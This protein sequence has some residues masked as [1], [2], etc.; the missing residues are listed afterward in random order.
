MDQ[1]EILKQL[2]Y[3]WQDSANEFLLTEANFLVLGGYPRGVEGRNSYISAR[4]VYQAFK[5]YAALPLNEQ[6]VYL[7]DGP[8]FDPDYQRKEQKTHFTLCVQGN[9]EEYS[10]A[11]ERIRELCSSSLIFKEGKQIKRQEMII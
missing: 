6:N 1:S 2:G 9:P 8:I 5:T 7:H 11:G 3:T 4:S 10:K